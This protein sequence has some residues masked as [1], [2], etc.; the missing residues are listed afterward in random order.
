MV[1]HP[2]RA[3]DFEDGM[4]LARQGEGGQQVC[5]QVVNGDRLRPEVL[6]V[7]GSP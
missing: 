6:L 2:I 1:R 7:K 5:H 3:A 4:A